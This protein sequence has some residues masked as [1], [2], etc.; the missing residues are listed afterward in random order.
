M[1]IFIWGVWTHKPRPLIRLC[2]DAILTLLTNYLCSS[3]NGG[4]ALFN[5]IKRQSKHH[6]VNAAEVSRRHNYRISTDDGEVLD[7]LLQQA[8]LPLLSEMEMEKMFRKYSVDNLLDS[9]RTS[10][11]GESD[12]SRDNLSVTADNYSMDLDSLVCA[13]VSYSSKVLHN[14]MQCKWIVI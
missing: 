8:T 7:R 1:N 5:S 11:S 10:L 3:A 14:V 12:T 6:P 13:S 4:P 2:L 9:S